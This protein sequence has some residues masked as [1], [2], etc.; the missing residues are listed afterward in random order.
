MN[1]QALVDVIQD[2]KQRVLAG[3]SRES[4]ASFALLMGGP[5]TFFAVF[6]CV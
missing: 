4:V 2:E 3:V 6:A 5:D 1:P